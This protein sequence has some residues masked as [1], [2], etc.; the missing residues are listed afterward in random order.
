MAKKYWIYKGKKMPVKKYYPETKKTSDQL[1]NELIRKVGQAN[2]RLRAIKREYGT[3][4]W[5]GESLKEKTTFYLVDTFRARGKNGIKVN[6]NMSNER[7]RSTLK[8]I[9]NF[10]QSKTS[11]IK[12]IEQTKKR[13]IEGLQKAFSTEEVE[14]T[15]EESKALYKRFEN[16]DYN[17]ILSYL[18]ASELNALIDDSKEHNDSLEQFMKRSE[19]YITGVV[20]IQLKQA[21]E[22]IYYKYVRS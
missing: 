21:L 17:Y 14:L 6:K 3:L 20:D 2:K 7:L 16:K 15:T 4:G 12:G 18:T 22:S 13:Q 19:N 11:S 9:N 1:Y 8:A 5:A 10:L